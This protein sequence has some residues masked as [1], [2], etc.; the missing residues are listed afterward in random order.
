VC[1][2][3]EDSLRSAGTGGFMMNT[4]GAHQFLTERAWM[5][6]QA[7]FGVLLPAWWTKHGSR[8]KLG[9]TASIKSPKMQA[10][11]GLSMESI[12][13]VDWQ[14]ALGGEPLTLA[15]LEELARHKASLVRWRGQ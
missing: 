10:S 5:L 3:I 7:G 6:E 4:P 9:A 15:E 2:E 11:A 8:L 12:V 14:V 13:Q 1:P